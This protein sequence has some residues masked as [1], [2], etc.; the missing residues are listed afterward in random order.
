MSLT[1][2]TSGCKGVVTNAM[3]TALPVTVI[4]VGIPVWTAE[5]M[6]EVMARLRLLETLWGPFIVANGKPETLAGPDILACEG[7]RCNVT[8]LTRTQFIR[9]HV[10]GF[11]K[12]W[13]T[14]AAK[15]ME[16]GTE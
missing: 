3:D 5:D 12:D 16:R 9:R 14:T 8:P 10:S 4:Q 1:I 13:T 7:L 15:A 2:D 6:P 11:M